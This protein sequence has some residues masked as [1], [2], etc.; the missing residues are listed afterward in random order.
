MGVEAVAANVRGR[1]HSRGLDRL[2]A[3]CT[4]QHSTQQPLFIQGNSAI[5]NVLFSSSLNGHQADIVRRNPAEV[6]VEMRAM[7]AAGKVFLQG[8]KLRCSQLT[9]GSER[10]KF[11]EP[12]VVRVTRI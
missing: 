6:G 8:A 9:T 3:S 2:L 1:T 7:R 5:L 4:R 12:L 11:L 10:A